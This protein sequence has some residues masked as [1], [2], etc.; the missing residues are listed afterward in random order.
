MLKPD[1]KKAVLVR[2][3]DDDAGVREAVSFDL[4]CRGWATQT[5]ESAKKFLASD[6][7]FVPGCLVLDI[8]M[9]EMS[10]LEL[11]KEMLARGHT[12]PIIILTGHGNID[13]SIKAFKLG[14][15]DFMQKPV[16]VEAFTEAVEK[17]C[18]LSFLHGQGLL[19]QKD[20]FLALSGMSARESEIVALLLQGLE[21]RD[22]AE[23]LNLSL[24]TVQGHRNNIYHKL[25]VHCLD[26]FIKAV[27]RAEEYRATLS[28]NTL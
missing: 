1:E 5:Y 15:F 2:I 13:V 16:D 20:C 27:A 12:L 26:D 22:I 24:R 11:Q 7:K 18:E 23:K 21:N 28:I 25:Q 19:S 9:P 3:V 4:E 14:A 8:R 10:G 17:A 6:D